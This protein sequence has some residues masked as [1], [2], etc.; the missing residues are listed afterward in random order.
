MCGSSSSLVIVPISEPC[1]Y[2]NI[3]F[4]SFSLENN[5]LVI[6]DTE[7]LLPTMKAAYNSTS[8]YSFY[9]YPIVKFQISEYEFC[10]MDEDSG[11]DPDH[12]DFILLSESRGCVELGNYSTLDSLS[13]IDFY[14]SN[15]QLDSLQNKTGFPNPSNWEYNLG[16]ANVPSWTY[17]CRHNYDRKFSI[18]NTRSQFNFEF[19]QSYTASIIVMAIFIAAIAVEVF[20]IV[21]RRIF[22]NSIYPVGYKQIYLPLDFCAA[23]TRYIYDLVAKLVILSVSIYLTWQTFYNWNWFKSVVNFNCYNSNRQM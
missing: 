5:S 15:P 4:S 23:I 2:V 8:P 10:L 14:A 19:F 12:S 9:T 21:V 13:E 18:P 3:S 7:S 17:P 16:F 6:S 20:V 22:N 11:I 1:P